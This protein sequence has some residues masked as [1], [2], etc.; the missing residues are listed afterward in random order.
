M[1]FSRPKRSR[2]SRRRPLRRRRATLDR[3]DV[4][5]TAELSRS[6]QASPASLV[7]A[8]LYLERLR[9]T[10]PSYVGGGVSSP[11]LFLVSLMVASKFL[12]DDGEDEEVF[13]DEWA[14]AAGMEASELNRKEI[15]FLEAIGWSVFVEPKEFERM[16]SR[17]ETAVAKRQVR[18]RIKF[19][20]R[21]I[22]CH[23]KNIGKS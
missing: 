19:F 14:E 3:L 8:L 9:A 13:N 16:R 18:C 7:V 23:C 5:R 12:H 21:K 2:S 17:V 10:N 22:N 6:T 11:D 4:S 20:K 1:A 15:E